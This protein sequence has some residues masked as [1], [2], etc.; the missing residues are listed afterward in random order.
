M[1][2]RGS[3]IENFDESGF[4]VASGGFDIWVSST[5]FQKR[6]IGW[7]QRPPTEKLLNF[8]LIFPDSTKILFFQKIKIKLNSRTWMTLKWSV[9]IFQTLETLS[10]FMTSSASA[11]SLASTAS[12]VIFSQ[13]LPDPDGLIILGTKPTNTSTFWAVILSVLVF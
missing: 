2:L 8:N 5:S 1:A 4:L 9:V 13:N 3:R 7:P 11:A 6:N 12:T 10:A